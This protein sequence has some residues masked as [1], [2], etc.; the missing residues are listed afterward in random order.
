MEFRPLNQ[1]FNLMG[2]YKGKDHF[3]QT[4]NF[5][6]NQIL[7]GKNPI[8]VTINDKEGDIFSTTPELYS[9]I[10][11]KAMMYSN[12]V[13][14][15]YKL[16]SKGEPEE[17][18]NTDVLKLLENPNPLQSRNEWLI[19]EMIHT[20]IYGNSLVYGLRGTRFQLPKALYNLPVN[21]V[22]VVP[23]GKIYK[24]YKLEDIIKEFVLT[25]YDGTMDK[26]EPKDVIYS[27]LTNPNNPLVGL[28][29]LQALQMPI[30]NIR[31]AYGYRNVLINERGAI[32]LLSNDTKD[33][34]G[35]VPLT[36]AEKKKIE[37]QYSKDYGIRDSQSKV[38]V[39][40]SSLKWTPMVYPTKD[41]MLFE[42]ITSDLR[43]ILD[44]YG[45]NEYLFSKES[46]T[47][48]NNL[49]EGK[50]M[51]YQDAIIPYA[52]DFSYKLSQYLGL[53]KINE[54][55]TIDYSHIEALQKSQKEQSEIL[56]NKAE[57]TRILFELGIY[58]PDEIKDI[59]Q[60]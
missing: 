38:M 28:S 21:R 18:F 11:R 13:F 33:M 39:T 58:N 3:T 45:L 34:D 19:E 31:G 44:A 10:M 54:F 48:Y 32:G 36:D 1:L 7:N 25:Y 16:N 12:G 47:S 5:Y 60:F 46:G 37:N 35:G 56:K 29:P 53:D 55:V 23:T 4:P 52:D 26:Y 17:L 42:E 57:A 49:L 43:I 27:R 41:L 50:R 20:S 14:K 8:W 6:Q 22:E 15:H 2:Y 40:S 24:Q 30:S 9:V 51:A 59:V